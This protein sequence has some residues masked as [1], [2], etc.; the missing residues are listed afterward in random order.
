MRSERLNPAGHGRVY[1]WTNTTLIDRREAVTRPQRDAQN[2]TCSI[3][4]RC[5]TRRVAPQR[6]LGGVIPRS[7]TWE[8]EKKEKNCVRSV[9]HAKF[10]ALLSQS[11]S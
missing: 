9:R 10:V 4:F 7:L 5:E 11:R 6:H 3:F 2:A 1:I 8:T